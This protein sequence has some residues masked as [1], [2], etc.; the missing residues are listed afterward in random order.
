MVSY[1]HKL[2]VAQ[3]RPDKHNAVIKVGQ[4]LG[5]GSLEDSRWHE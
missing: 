4:A 3:A 5:N 1:L 2:G